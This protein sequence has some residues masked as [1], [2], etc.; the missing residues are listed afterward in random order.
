MLSDF[1]DLVNFSVMFCVLSF[2]VCCAMCFI[3]VSLWKSHCFPY[4]CFCFCSVAVCFN[5]CSV[6]GVWGSL[7]IFHIG[8]FLLFCCVMCSVGGS[9]WKSH[10]FPYQCFCFCSVLLWCVLFC[11][12]LGEFVKRKGAVRFWDIMR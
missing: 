6:W 8:V 12:L 9:L 7:T 11:V 3:W 2:G 1:K 5:L 10:C 4:Q